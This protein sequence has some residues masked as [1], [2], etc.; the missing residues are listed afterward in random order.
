M[1]TDD[2]LAYKSPIT[3]FSVFPRA[4]PKPTNKSS[5]AHL[6]RSQAFA[7]PISYQ[8]VVALTQQILRGVSAGLCPLPALGLLPTLGPI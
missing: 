6:L 7:V 1:R 5:Q 4:V 3:C 2:A 8:Q